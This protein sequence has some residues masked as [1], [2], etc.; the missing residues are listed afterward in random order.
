MDNL[1]ILNNVLDYMQR[2]GGGMDANT[3]VLIREVIKTT[4]G[5][6]A[7]LSWLVMVLACNPDMID[8]LIE[9]LRLIDNNVSDEHKLKIA[10]TGDT[11]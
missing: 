3:A 10:M 8:T 5:T 11:K 4:E 2:T 1:K 6:S 9:N 7:L